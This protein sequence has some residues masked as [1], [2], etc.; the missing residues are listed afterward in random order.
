MMTSPGSWHS[1]LRSAIFCLTPLWLQQAGILEA[2]RCPALSF[3]A[4]ATH[5]ASVRIL[6]GRLASCKP[7][8][9]WHRLGH[10]PPAHCGLCCTLKLGQHVFPSLLAGLQ[11]LGAAQAAIRRFEKAGTKWQRPPDFYAEMV[12]SDQ[13]MARVK[14]QLMHEQQ[15]MEQADERWG[16]ASP[17]ALH[18]LPSA[19]CVSMPEQQLMAQVRGGLCIMLGA[20][21]FVLHCCM[22]WVQKQ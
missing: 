22:Q 10:S 14:E 5:T 6:C 16:A 1:T 12:K 9:K 17:W 19:S 3:C 8:C 2:R 7:M 13:H 21:C 11:A 18:A 20:A 15:H 4:T